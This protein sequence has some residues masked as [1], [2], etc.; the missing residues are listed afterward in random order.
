MAKISLRAYTQEIERL[1]ENKR[2][3]EAVAHCHHILEA[4]PKH[5]DTYRQFGKAYLEQQRFGDAADIF[6]RVLSAIPDDFISHVG[7]SIIREDE[8]NLDEALFH[9]QQASETQPSNI[10]IQDELRRLYG[11]RDGIE[12]PKIRLTRGALARMYIKGEL[13]QQASVE[14]RAALSEDANRIDLQ[15]LLAQIYIKTGKITDALELARNILKKLPNSYDANH[16]LARYLPASGRESEAD[17]YRQVI[18]QLN[19][20]AAYTSDE[21]PSVDQVPEQTVLLERLEW[22]AGMDGEAT[23]KQPAW[24]ESLGLELGGVQKSVEEEIPDWM[25]SAGWEAGGEENEL[26]Q[27]ELID[28]YKPDSGIEKADIPDWL[29]EIAPQESELM[30]DDLDESETEDEDVLPWLEKILPTSPGSELEMDSEKLA[31]SG[32]LTEDKTSVDLSEAETVLPS[33][34]NNTGDREQSEEAD[35][36]PDWLAAPA[37]EAKPSGMRTPPKKPKPNWPQRSPTG[38]LPPLRKSKP[39]G[40]R[41]PPKKRKPN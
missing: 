33:W 12:P 36:I 27:S 8:G 23:S 34:L 10:A 16:I 30:T 6:Q 13:Y 5:I 18:N 3:D 4:Y 26:S 39:P 38:W 22:K 29:K 7:M 21:V 19:P 14:I 9:I 2:L 1:I 31:F 25:R 11:R 28:E 17:Q 40:M 32:D 41:T 24:A 37:E 15:S 20:Y 35:E